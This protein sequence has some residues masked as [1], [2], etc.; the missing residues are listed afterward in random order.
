MKSKWIHPGNESSSIYD[1]TRD[2]NYVAQGC[3][4]L[5]E[6]IIVWK[7]G[8]QVILGLLTE[9]LDSFHPLAVIRGKVK[10]KVVPEGESHAEKPLAPKRSGLEGG[11]GEQ[12]VPLHPLSNAVGRGCKR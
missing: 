5:T 9:A 10:S 11:G 8:D 3:L 4:P 7:K 6:A 2:Q 12:I 1:V